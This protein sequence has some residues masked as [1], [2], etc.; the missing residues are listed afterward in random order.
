MKPSLIIM[1]AGMG[2]RFG[3]PKQITPIDDAGHVILDYSAFDAAR[4]GFGR[5]LCVIKK[6]M[7]ADFRAAVGDRIARHIPVEYAYQQLSDLPGGYTVAEGRVKPLGT[8]HAVLACRHLLRGEP[9]AVINADDFYG[10]GAFEALYRFLSAPGPDNRHCLVAYELKNCLTDNGTVARG[11]CSVRGDGSLE[12]VTERTKIQ[13]PAQSPSYTEDGETWI[14]LDPNAPVSLNTW[15]FRPG[16]MAALEEEFIKFLRQD[17]PQN[18]EKAEFF[19]PFAVNARLA[20]G[21]DS[22]AVVPTEE[23]WYGMTYK[24]D[25]P[26]VRQAI[27]RM[28][29]EGKYPAGLWN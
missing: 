15:G 10:R 27:A 8:G 18:P 17:L 28:T 14:P 3:G 22:A 23:C 11:I 4:A 6:E 29:A 19:L 25:M 5:I 26:V 9:F 16:F 1:A 2:S 7:E 21:T 12:T 20:A 24:E 13:G